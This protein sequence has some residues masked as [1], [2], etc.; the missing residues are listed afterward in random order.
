MRHHPHTGV[1][2]RQAD[3]ALLIR[4]LL[5]SIVHICLL[6]RFRPPYLWCVYGF[7]RTP[8]YATYEAGGYAADDAASL[9]NDSFSIAACII[10]F[11][12]MM[13]VAQITMFLRA[14]KA[15]NQ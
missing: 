3:T 1:A 5:A 6:D 7:G 13:D 14:D 10:R 2:Y 9:P 8:R 12:L 15:N 4:G 11:P